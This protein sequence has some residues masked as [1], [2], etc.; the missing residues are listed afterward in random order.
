MKDLTIIKIG[1]NAIIDDKNNVRQDLLN[2]I[3]VNLLPRTKAGEKFIIVASGSVAMGRKEV[4]NFSLEKA[5]A[6]G[7]GQPV[8]MQYF[9]QA[10]IK[11]GFKVAELLLSRP[12]LIKRREFLSLQE[13]IENFL[14]HPD[15]ILVI[16]END[17]LVNGTDW[18]FGD[19]DSLAGALAVAL[20]AQKL[21]LVS[22]I[23]GLY[24]DGK[25]GDENSLISE[26]KDVNAELMKYCRADIS[27]H[28]TG[29]MLSKLKVARLC[30]AVCIETQII[31]G[32]KPGNLADALSRKKIGTTFLPH[33]SCQIIK[34]RERWILAARTSAGS[35]MI[36][37][38]AGRALQKGKSLLAVGIKKIIGSFE[39]DELVEVVNQSL[40]TIAI[41]V[42]DMASGGLQ[43]ID[44]KEQK[45]VQVMHAD[46]IMVL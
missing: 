3:F 8:L 22:T 31:N 16:N 29:G 34:N 41:G 21:L 18:G 27:Q 12:H 9:K 25:I 17:F 15:F 43:K 20:S 14:S 33:K 28:G 4:N 23:D 5:L 13:K 10:G 19:N 24:E 11:Y 45:G 6:A 26:V 42:A 2:E 32:L 38:G 40:E 46:N 1:T 39:Q 35:I 37:D 36:D 7:I 30:R 44:F